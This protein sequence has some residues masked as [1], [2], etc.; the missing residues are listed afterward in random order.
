MLSKLTPIAL[1][2]W[3]FGVYH[4]RWCDRADRRAAAN[5]RWREINELRMAHSTPPAIAFIDEAAGLTWDL[6]QEQTEIERS[7][8]P[9]TWVHRL[10]WWLDRHAGV[11]HP[12]RT[13]RSFWHRGRHGW[14][15]RDTYNLDR[16]LSRVTAD[17]L[18]Y[19][20]QNLSGYPTDLTEESWDE[21]LRQIERGLRAHLASEPI[22]DSPADREAAIAALT[23]DELSQ[24]SDFTT[25]DDLLVDA[26]FRTALELL[27]ARFSS[28]WD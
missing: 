24:L 28:L 27:T 1:W 25:I 6:W 19:F 17:A 11:S 9:H 5:P 26:Q 15:P 10:D 22:F 21:L 16:Y 14:A 3:A 23:P 8:T 2:K 20:R 13:F 12:I 18:V 7:I 4:S